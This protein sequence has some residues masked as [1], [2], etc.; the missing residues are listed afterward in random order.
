[1]NI[2]RNTYE[3]YFIDYLNGNLSDYELKQLIDFLDHNP[4]LEQELKDITSFSK[5]TK[6]IPDSKHTFN[7]QSL[8]KTP[9]LK[10]SRSNFDELC[11]SFHEGLL[12]E[13]EE[14]EFLELIEH[15]EEFESSFNT[16]A[17][18]KLKADTNI[19]FP[20]KANLKKQ[21]TI[22]WQRYLSYVASIALIISFIIYIQNGNSEQN[23]NISKPYTYSDISTTTYPNTKAVE[24]ETQSNT[25]IHTEKKAKINY[26][27]KESTIQKQNPVR[28][29]RKTIPITQEE[30]ISD[31]YENNPFP[32]SYSR[33]GKL[34]YS[35]LS[36]L[37]IHLA[38]LFEKKGI[39]E[40]ALS[41]EVEKMTH[42]KEPFQPNN[43]TYSPAIQN[44]ASINPILY[45]KRILGSQPI[46][47]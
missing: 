13:Q 26:I 23:D 41:Q 3:V 40:E 6:L 27:A 24:K 28:K 21:P 43:A 20:N 1:M 12:N 29:T 16:Y 19:I 47:E 30:T 10:D 11:I 25:N 33:K 38:K 8:K 7:A 44:V 46:D 14:Y 5:N 31:N 15:K 35:N 4:D 39:E 45:Q 32:L 36:E 34:A 42:K 2:N 17:Q 18:T 37:E 9:I 22:Y